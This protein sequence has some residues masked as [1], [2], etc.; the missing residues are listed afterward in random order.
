[1]QKLERF[2]LMSSKVV[3]ITIPD[4]FHLHL[5]DG[6]NMEYNFLRLKM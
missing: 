4:D 5:R 2:A 3:E 6:N 1:M